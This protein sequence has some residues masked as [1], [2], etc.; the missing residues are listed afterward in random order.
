[1]P[2]T[3]KPQPKMHKKAQPYDSTLKEWV[4]QQ[5]PQILPLLLSG[6]SYLETMD[7]ERIRPTMR[8][9]RV[10]KVIYRGEPH[11]LHIEFESGADNHMVSRLLL[12]HA[13]LY[14]DYKLPVISIILYPFQVAMAKSP[15]CEMS[16]EEAI[17]T[18]N[19]RIL[20]LYSLDAEY[21]LREHLA[22]MYPLL[23][24]MHNVSRAHIEEAMAELAS[25]YR[26]DKTTLAQQFAWMELL[27]ERTASI[28]PQEKREVQ[29]R[30]SMYD[31]LWEEHPKVKQ[32]K[33]KAR[34]EVREAKA[35]ARA[36]ARAEAQTEIQEARAEAQEAKA[37]MQA[38]M[39]AEIQKLAQE[40]QANAEKLAQELVKVEAARIKMELE[41]LAEERA[42]QLAEERAKQLAKEHAKQLAEETITTLREALITLVQARF[43]TLTE[44]AQTNVAQV[45]TPQVLSY[46]LKQI[47][48]SAD[49]NVA[50]LFL[51]SMAA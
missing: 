20:P 25:L 32:I 10:Y 33:A 13:I 50:R 5:A 22:C 36:E 38:E 12:Y 34:A 27:L 14:R 11:I 48:A 16:G 26:D 9:D 1:M 46:L 21:Y 41:Q 44:L 35:E 45:D 47:A 31:P 7:I 6:A 30:L 15:W 51:R 23:P 8:T 17:L 39:Q 49:E 2:T 24:T 40:A 3:E 42:K 29:R 43:P 28:P 4:Q 18:F 37:E 19:F